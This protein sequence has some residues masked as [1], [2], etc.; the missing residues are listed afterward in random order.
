[1]KVPLWELVKCNFKGIA[2]DCYLQPPADP[3]RRFPVAQGVFT[4]TSLAEIF[5]RL[6]AVFSMRRDILADAREISGEIY[7]CE[8]LCGYSTFSVTSGSSD[9]LPQT[10]LSTEEYSR[11][12]II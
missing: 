8:R 4:V 5:E 9:L 6:F 1:M 3:C 7:P 2:S 12:F 10:W 11:R